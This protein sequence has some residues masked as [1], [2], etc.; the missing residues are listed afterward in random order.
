MGNIYEQPITHNGKYKI[1][2]Y[3]SNPS[4]D[5]DQ[6]FPIAGFL[7]KYVAN[8]ASGDYDLNIQIPNNPQ[9]PEI[10]PNTCSFKIDN[11]V[12]EYINNYGQQGGQ[13]GTLILP[14]ND[15]NFMQKVE[16]NINGKN[17][18]TEVAIDLSDITFP[19][20]TIEANPAVL[21]I[22]PAVLEFVNNNPTWGNP[23]RV[24]VPDPI[25]TALTDYED[26]GK[27]YATNLTI[28]VGSLAGFFNLDLNTRNIS[29]NG[30]Y[31]IG[32]FDN[33]AEDIEIERQNNRG[34]SIRLIEDGEEDGTKGDTKDDPTP[35]PNPNANYTMGTF[36]VNVQPRLENKTVT[37]T[38]TN[39][40]QT[41]THESGYDGLGIVTINS[42]VSIP[43]TVVRYITMADGV[44]FTTN[45]FN[46]PGSIF[47]IYDLFHNHVEGVT[48][49]KTLPP[50]TVGATPPTVTLYN[51]T[52]GHTFGYIA[53]QKLNLGFNDGNLNSD[54]HYANTTY[55]PGFVIYYRYY[56]PS[57]INNQAFQTN[58][59]DGQIDTNNAKS[60]IA[61]FDTN[62]LNNSVSPRNMKGLLLDENRKIINIM[63]YDGYISGFSEVWSY[64]PSS[65]YSLSDNNENN[66]DFDEIYNSITNP[67]Q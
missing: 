3:E 38:T 62:E 39:G 40:T 21:E 1:V 41:V 6:G 32:N 17:Y 14:S 12:V 11:E 63:G 44:E 51:P 42:N 53:I 35:T 55:N 23:G 52:P 22:T 9:P 60:I 7:P 47:N 34:M 65:I 46:V 37:V 50:T 58:L 10:T 20:P 24:T 5:P 16:F 45:Y 2:P 31:Q 28:N 54:N 27:G 18:A 64:L 26:N 66:F 43:K 29:Q 33:N 13:Q 59:W 15:E 25:L 49:Y 48:L 4:G 61:V 8:Q 56:L 19:E 30:T 36:T 67:T 57:N